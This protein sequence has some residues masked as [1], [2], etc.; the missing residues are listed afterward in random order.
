MKN[1]TFSFLL[2]L[3]MNMVASV[4]SAHDFAVNGIY[5]EITSSTTPYT[6]SVTYRGSSS[7][8]YSNRYTGS[9]TIPETVTYNGKTYSV[10]SIGGLAFYGCTGL[11]SISIPNSVTSIGDHAFYGCTGLTSVEIPNNV[12]SIGSSAFEKCTGLTS[13]VVNSGNIKFDSRNGC[14][15]I[16]ETA[17]NTLIAGCK[18]TIIPNSVTSIGSSAFEYCS[19]LTSIEIPYSVTSIGS[20][21][22]RDC[23]GLTSIVIGNSVTSIGSSAFRDCYGLTSIVIGNSVTSIGEAAFRD[24]SSLISIEIPNSVTSI[25]DYAFRDCS[26]LTSIKIPNSVTLIGDY[27]FRDC[28]KLTKAEFSSIGHYLNGISF[29]GGFASDSNPL[30]KAHHLYIGG[31]EV[32]NLVI[33]N[34]V[35]SIGSSAFNGC[36]GLIS[37]SIPNSVTSIGGAVFRGC[38]GL[39]SIEIPNSVTSIGDYAFSGCTALKDVTINSNAIAS[40]TYTSSS[41][42]SEIFGSQVTSYA[43]GEGVEKIGDYACYNLSSITALSLPESVN[44]IGSYVFRGCSGLTSIEIPNSVT[45]IGSSA[46]QN[47]TGLTKAEFASVEHYLNGISFSGGFASDSNPLYKAH[48]LYVGGSEVTNLVIPNIVTS[49]GNGAFRGCSSLISI[50]IP[51]SVTSIGSNSFYGCTALVAVTINSNAIASKSYTNYSRLS[52]IFGSQV[53]EYTFGEG[54]DKIGDYACY[55]CSNMTVLNLPASLTTIGQYTFSECIGLTSFN[56]TDGIV[57][58]GQSAF[59]ANATLNVN[60]GT[61]SLLALWKAGYKNPYEKGTENVL[62]PSSLNLVGTTQM[63][64]TVKVNNLYQ[65]YENTLKGDIIKEAGEYVFHVRPESSQTATLK[66]SKGGVVYSHPLTYRT[67]NISPTAMRVQGTASSMSVKASYLEGDAEVT[68]QTLTVNG[69]TVEGDSLYVN[70]L[71]PGTSYEAQYTIVVDGQYEYTGTVNL[72]TDALYFVNEQPKVINEGNVIIGATS[73]LDWEETN[74]GFQWRR[75][76]WTDD[77]ASN[78][79]GAYQ[80]EGKIEGYIRNMNTTYLWRFRP[81]YES[82]DGTRFYGDWLGIDPTNTSYFE[83]T[84]HT[85]ANI[86][87]EGNSAEVKGYAQRG[88]DNVVSQGFMYWKASTTSTTSPQPSPKAREKAPTI[89]SGAQKVEATGTVMEASLT[90][91]EYESTYSYV[92]FV[93]TSEGETFYGEEKTFTTGAA[94]T[95]IEEIHNSQFTMHNGIYDLSGRQIV[96]SSNRKLQRGIYIKN[97]KKFLVK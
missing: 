67:L 24:C 85:Y 63:T 6:A 97:G 28:S 19:G 58:V 34:T 96:K 92:A 33:P 57:S 37:I 66:V 62:V 14:N 16:I 54:V 64:A 95:G 10:T 39:T 53:T 51:N 29:S 82:A 44:S 8:S 91:L 41:R 23:Y 56:L 76:D 40:K 87:V 83:P 30:Y 45:S 12:T 52:E 4:A 27:A 20:S 42:L 43:F 15:A 25:G 47:C 72:R 80:F 59:P 13:I 11:T 46:F 38:T 60:R 73:N 86:T 22:F 71:K 77:F 26:N 75:T 5:Y 70:G 79:A 32:T 17:S 74:V 9:V 93:K 81:Y 69:V 31:S 7:S 49:I 65:E 68:S 94:P 18:N 89:P 48:H 84:V 1:K 21:A 88:T 35:N 78:E 61:K 36:T 90:G 50:E 3:L 55:G 2:A